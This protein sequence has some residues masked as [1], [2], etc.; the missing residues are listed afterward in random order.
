M[1]N[2]K[3]WYIMI[4]NEFELFIKRAILPSSTLLVI[5]LVVGAVF[6]NQNY[7]YD[8]Y[9]TYKPDQ[10]IIIVI[11]CVLILG[12]NYLLK[13]MSQLVF[14][15]W[16]KS[17]YDS[18][19]YLKETEAL[20]FLRNKVIDKLNSTTTDDPKKYTDYILYQ[21]TQKIT[22]YDTKRYVTDS[23]EASITF[24]SLG[25]VGTIGFSLSNIG[26]IYI[27][28]SVIIFLGSI[29]FIGFE[30][31]KSKYRSRAFRLYVNYLLYEEISEEPT[32]PSKT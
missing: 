23:K 24:V 13:I 16:I 6:Y 1:K 22:G 2:T 25:L 12:L 11:I 20:Q 7:I 9:T 10:W 29:W 19:I 4:W 30:Y 14:D 3:Q 17:N 18:L 28:L 15:N 21:Y 8:F 26:I 5:Y 32:S 27:I 31:I